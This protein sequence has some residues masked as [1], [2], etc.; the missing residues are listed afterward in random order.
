MQTPSE[1]DIN[2]GDIRGME[3]KR[4]RRRRPRHKYANVG[5]LFLKKLRRQIV[6][7]VTLL[8]LTQCF[9]NILSTAQPKPNLNPTQPNPTQPLKI[10]LAEERHHSGA[11]SGRLFQLFQLRK[12][13]HFDIDGCLNHSDSIA[14]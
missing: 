3:R 10:P 13:R 5:Q 6:W 7:M 4:N 14:S 11:K 12:P 1:I 9:P 8:R 2:I